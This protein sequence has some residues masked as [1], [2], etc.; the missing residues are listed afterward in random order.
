MTEPQPCRSDGKHDGA[1]WPLIA[2][3]S[4]ME[5]IR[6]DQAA[7]LGNR[8]RQIAQL[9]TTLEEVRE[10]L[11]EMTTKHS[12]VSIEA[13]QLDRAHDKRIGELK[14]ARESRD[15]WEAEHKNASAVIQAERDKVVE[16]EADRAKLA[17][18]LVEA[19]RDNR[20]YLQM[21]GERD[22]RATRLE[23]A[24]DQARKEVGDLN[25]RMRFSA[26]RSRGRGHTIRQ[27]RALVGILRSGGAIEHQPF[28]DANAPYEDY[29]L[30]LD[31]S[32]TPVAA[33]PA[34]EE[35]PNAWPP[36]GYDQAAGPV[37]VSL[38]TGDP[39]PR[40]ETSSGGYPMQSTAFSSRFTAPVDGLYS[41]GSDGPKLMERPDPP[42]ACELE[43]IQAITQYTGLGAIFDDLLAEYMH[44]TKRLNAMPPSQLEELEHVW[45]ARAWDATR[46]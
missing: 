44:L 45:K 35:G 26:K 2:C 36:F 29:G 46:V 42:L 9:K 21:I 11:A 25:E 33:A 28:E 18:Q 4:C 34:Q 13:G 5:D 14:S 20:E 19:Q 31:L 22:A 27:L 12:R 37:R 6:R 3:V 16:L 38:H 32:Q 23:E 43:P 39:I 40:G 7:V 17:G 8:D 15:F 41:L 30:A 10:R 24:R 1:I